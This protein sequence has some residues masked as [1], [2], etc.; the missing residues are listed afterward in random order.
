MLIID[1]DRKFFRLYREHRDWTPEVRGY[2]ID[3]EKKVSPQQFVTVY[4]YANYEQAERAMIMYVM[5][6]LHQGS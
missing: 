6:I 2:T 4:R 5:K 3:E 1:R